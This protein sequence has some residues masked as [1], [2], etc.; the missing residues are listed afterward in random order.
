LLEL[1]ENVTGVRFL[2]H[3]PSV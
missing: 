2:R 3:N 1:F